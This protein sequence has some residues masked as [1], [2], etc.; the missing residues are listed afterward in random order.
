V[1]F[2]NHVMRFEISS[3]FCCSMAQVSNETLQLASLNF[4]QTVD[5]H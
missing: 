3:Q 4:R 2:L 5:F 1:G